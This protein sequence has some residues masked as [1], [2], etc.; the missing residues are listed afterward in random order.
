MIAAYPGA[1][2]KGAREMTQT[3]D[4][5]NDILVEMDTYIPASRKRKVFNF[6]WKWTKRLCLW[7]FLIGTIT[8]ISLTIW[9]N[10]RGK[11]AIEQIK[12]NISI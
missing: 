5:L 10:H 6:A 1:E 3:A 9:L 4:D 8:T 2:L 12:D 11:K 7:F